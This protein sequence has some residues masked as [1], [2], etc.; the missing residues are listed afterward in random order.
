MCNYFVYQPNL[1]G[2]VT[3]G[4]EAPRDMSRHSILKNLKTIEGGHP[5]LMGELNVKY[6]LD[7][8]RG[9]IREL[10]DVIEF[11]LFV[12]ING[13]FVKH[14]NNSANDTTTQ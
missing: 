10:L 4:V 5:A 11:P 8:F 3:F 1:D 13:K 2:D 7:S 14:S 6:L 12:Y 9:E